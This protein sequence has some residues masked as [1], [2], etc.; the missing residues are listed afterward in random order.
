M[1]KSLLLQAAFMLLTIGAAAQ[2]NSGD[3]IDYTSPN[4]TPLKIRFVQDAS[5][6]N[7]LR[8]DIYQNPG[9]ATW[10]DVIEIPSTVTYQGTDYTVLEI[11]SYAFNNWNKA[12]GVILPSTITKINNNAFAGCVLMKT[13]NLEQLTNLTTIGNFAFQN[14]KVLAGELKLPANITTLG[15][16]VFLNCNALS[17]NLTLP[18]S[19]KTIGNECFRGCSAMKGTLMLNEGLE[20]VGQRAFYYTKF[21]G[22]LSVPQSVTTLAA[23][24]F[25]HSA[26]WT[27]VSFAAGSQLASIGKTAINNDAT[28][29][30]VFGNVDQYIDMDACTGMVNE[31]TG[32][33]IFNRGTGNDIF[34]GTYAW[35][36]IYLPSGKGFS[37]SEQTSQNFV[38]DGTCV[39]L[40]VYDTKPCPILHPFTA[41]TAT[42]TGRDFAAGSYN[43]LCLP[44]PTAIP[45]GAK[46]YTLQS[47]DQAQATATFI[48]FNGAS[49]A[50]NTPYLLA[51]DANATPI[52]AASEAYMEQ[53]CDV[54]VSPAL[55]P[56]TS[57]NPAFIGTTVRL[58]NAEV[59]TQYTAPYNLN[60]DQ[61]WYPITTSNAADHVEPFR[62]FIDLPGSNA[63]KVLMVLDD[64]ATGISTVSINDLNDGYHTFYTPDGKAAGTNLDSLPSGQMYVISGKKIYKP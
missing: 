13:A 37:G 63:A 6:S 5:A 15:D 56:N 61:A 40:K 10:A 17:G 64:T 44:Y 2:P 18:A 26:H 57:G 33:D 21:I 47:F 43:T 14:C 29:G 54:P 48:P 31:A 42:Y 12:T 4:G 19:L 52:A 60:T 50:A 46:A 11:S 38:H 30:N 8:A 53:N 45:A 28:S 36:L 49:L 59:T 35:T 23:Q 27:S 58:T 34:S 55:M 24:A 3:I 39:K 22:S 51:F 41:T 32:S 9:G 62:G 20:S 1:R 7:G 16:K 25:F